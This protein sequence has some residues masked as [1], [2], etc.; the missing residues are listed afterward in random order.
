M[1]DALLPAKREQNKELQPHHIRLL[2]Y[3]ICKQLMDK[4]GMYYDSYRQMGEGSQASFLF[5]L[6]EV[7]HQYGMWNHACFILDKEQALEGYVRW[8][9]TLSKLEKVDPRW[10]EYITIH[11]ERSGIQLDVGGFRN[12]NSYSAS[13]VQHRISYGGDK[14]DYEIM[15]VFDGKKISAVLGASDDIIGWLPLEKA[16][17]IAHATLS[18]DAAR[19]RH[20]VE[21]AYQ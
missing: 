8:Q 11:A 5:R 16:V 14:G 3:H 12:D 20:A 1:T 9:T 4:Q 13:I 10:K 2:V 15:P 19:F 6:A 7:S 18:R 21:T 17:A